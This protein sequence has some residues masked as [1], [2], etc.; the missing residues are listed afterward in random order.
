MMPKIEHVVL[1]PKKDDT[2]MFGAK[3][4]GEI[5]LVPPAPAIALAYRRLDGVFRDKLP[6]E[7]TAY[8]K[9]GLGRYNENNDRA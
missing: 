8:R 5:V 6:L 9:G 7:K 3:G 4:V 1:E 2:L